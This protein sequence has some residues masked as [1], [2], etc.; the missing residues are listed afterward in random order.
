[1][2]SSK[3]ERLGYAPRALK[4]RMLIIRYQL[5]DDIVKSRLSVYQNYNTTPA[6]GCQLRRRRGGPE[7]EVYDDDYDTIPR[8]G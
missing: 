8:T 1:M 4:Y 5:Q 3:R 7:G 2:I 6:A